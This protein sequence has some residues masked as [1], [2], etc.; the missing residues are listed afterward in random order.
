MRVEP[1]PNGEW[2]V[3]EM[4]SVLAERLDVERPEAHRI[5]VQLRDV[6]GWRLEAYDNEL[7]KK[8]RAFLWDL[9]L[10]GIVTTETRTRPHPEHGRPW[11]YHHWKLIP[12]EQA[13]AAKEPEA[14]PENAPP[15][16]GLYDQLPS[17]AWRR[18]AVSPA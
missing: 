3:E 16:I 14:T 5:A 10:E 6:F 8:D 13:A 18:H 17:D 1:A 15:E 9:L 12:P 7:E 4:T 2:P 11:R